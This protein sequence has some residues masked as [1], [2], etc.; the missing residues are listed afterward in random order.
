[1]I[2][3]LDPTPEDTKNSST[4]VDQIKKGV[5]QPPVGVD[6]I[7]VGVDQFFPSTPASP[8]GDKSFDG[9]N[10][11][12]SVDGVDQIPLLSTIYPPLYEEKEEE[13]REKTS[14]ADREGIS[15]TPPTLSTPPHH[16]N[17]P[18][19][20]TRPCLPCGKKAWHFNEETSNYY[21]KNC[22]AGKYPYP[23]EKCPNCQDIRW[24]LSPQNEWK[25][26]NCQDEHAGHDDE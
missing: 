10:T 2:S 19:Q 4:G 26:V 13:K 7:P 22:G 23:V 3:N 25:C 14:R 17:R 12:F 11:K 5:D 16:E 15:S 18:K 24:F 8:L 9:K 21:C 20:P 6:Q 1:M